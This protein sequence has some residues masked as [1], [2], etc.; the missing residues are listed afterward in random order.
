[1]FI[2][3]CINAISLTK[4]LKYPLALFYKHNLMLSKMDLSSTNVGVD[5]I[6]CLTVETTCIAFSIFIVSG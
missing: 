6:Y 1:M 4:T 5:H 3:R 2:D